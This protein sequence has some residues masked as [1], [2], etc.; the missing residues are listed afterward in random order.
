MFFLLGAAHQTINLGKLVSTVAW[1]IMHYSS[2]SMFK[3]YLEPIYNQIGY[4]DIGR[5]P[6][7]PMHTL[8]RVRDGSFDIEYN[9][10]DVELLL[11]IFVS[12]VYEEQL[13][14]SV[15]V[16]TISPSD[17]TFTCNFCSSVIWNRHLHCPKCP[18]VDL[19]FRCFIAGRSCKFHYTEYSFRQL[20]PWE[21]CI[22]LIRAIEE[23][24]GRPTNSEIPRY[25]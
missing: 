7:V 19:C 3:N 6:L 10:R 14:S 4:E 24:L 12:M 23:K 5:V 1:N 16:K 15:T 18:D 22:S 9:R 13:P 25:V 2:V 21:S 11:D 20:M 8:Q 17:N